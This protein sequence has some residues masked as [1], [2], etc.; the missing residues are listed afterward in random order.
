MD[1]QEITLFKEFRRIRFY[2]IILFTDRVTNNIANFCRTNHGSF[3]SSLT[4]DFTFNLG[5][6]PP[7]YASVST[8]RNTTLLCKETKNSPVILGPKLI[9][10]EKDDRS[11]KLLCD[12]IA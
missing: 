5:K 11:V 7:Y 9:Y 6:N 4:W 2:D 1:I 10:H 12:T 3:K 8:Y